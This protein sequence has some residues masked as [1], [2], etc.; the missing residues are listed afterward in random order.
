VYYSLA[1]FV[2]HK[3]PPRTYIHQTRETYIRRKNYGN[4]CILT[5]K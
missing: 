2:L 5:K 4:L 3:D 1:P